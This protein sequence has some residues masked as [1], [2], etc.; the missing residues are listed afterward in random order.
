MKIAVI[1]CGSIGRRHIGNLTALGVRSLSAF[2]ANPERLAEVRPIA[3]KA[4]TYDDLNLLFRE[5]HPGAAVIALPTSLHT[6]FAVKAAQAGCHLFIEK[7][8]SKDLSG[9]DALSGLVKAKRL[10]AF[11]GYNFRFHSSLLRLKRELGLGVIGKVLSGRTHFG[12]YLPSRHPGED[13]R[14]GYG[15]KRSMGGGV[16]LDALSHP[17]EY[18]TFLLGRP[19]EV[20]CYAGK[21]S[22]LELDAEDVAE[23]WMRFENGAVVSLH[24]DFVQRPYKHTLELI[25]ENG[26]VICDWF[27]RSVRTYAAK[28]GRWVTIRDRR[29]LNQMYLDEMRCFISC[30]KGRAKPPVDLAEGLRQMRVLI[31]IKESAVKRKW[32]KV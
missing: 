2:D 31:K 29:S 24:G 4:R 22:A 5:E 10:T 26:T 23:I 15:A 3:P 7:P 17:V 19:K 6:A 1:G 20:L 18:L 12:S 27:A 28:T 9:T 8:L 16:I 30:L 25:G 21:H 11:V 14:K 13:Y 32:V